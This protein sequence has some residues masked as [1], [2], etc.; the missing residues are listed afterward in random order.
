M[1]N[2]KTIVIIA[3]A[4]VVIGGAILWGKD[5]LTDRHI[6]TRH[7]KAI[8]LTQKQEELIKHYDDQV[9]LL[10]VKIN[11]LDNNQAVTLEQDSLM[12][13]RLLEIDSMKLSLELDSFERVII[14]ESKLF[15]DD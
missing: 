4:V 13:I 10:T 3:E 6:L 15:G 5:E 11:Q 1:K 9:K 14:E 7:N 12:N 8:E 2:L